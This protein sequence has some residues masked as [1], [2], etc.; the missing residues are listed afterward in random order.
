MFLVSID[1]VV[2]AHS[3]LTNAYL[4]KFRT[5]IEVESKIYI[6]TNILN[7]KRNHRR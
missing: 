5:A 2:R 1:G 6:H 4:Y 7:T 3:L